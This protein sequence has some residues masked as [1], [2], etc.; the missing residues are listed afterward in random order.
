L[1]LAQS[2]AGVPASGAPPEKLA[3]A[4][5]YPSLLSAFGLTEARQVHLLA[6]DE[7][8]YAEPPSAS[9]HLSGT[10]VEAY[11][12]LLRFRLGAG[13]P[14]PPA[15]VSLGDEE[16]AGLLF[17][18]AL[19]LSGVVE[20]SGRF[21]GREGANLWVKTTEGRVGLPVDPELPLARKVGDRY[22]PSASLTLRAGDRLRWWK[23]GAQT[24]GLWVEWEAAGTTFER[25]SSWTEWVRRVSSRELA[26]RM[27]QRVVG[28]EVRDLTVVRRS[29]SGRVIEMEVVTDG[30]KLDLKRFDVRQALEL[31]ELLFTA[32]KVKGPQGESEWVFLGRGWG[33]GVGLCQNGAYGMALAGATYDAILKHYYAGIDIV[34][35][36]SVQ[37]STASGR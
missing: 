3:A 11:N 22:F 18:A 8:Y 14:L 6:R 26:R 24:L 34:P 35:A 21:V 15:D 12:F 1:S 17:S 31:P 7:S 29:P 20:G 19:R 9:G 2:W 30:G 27:S 10:A 36:N 33:H 28:T 37:A 23:R 16:Y 5:V 32:E 25:D 4:A 13:E